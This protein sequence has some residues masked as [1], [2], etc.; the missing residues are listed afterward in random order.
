VVGTNVKK[1]RKPDVL[2]VVVQ[3]AIR[4]VKE[5]RLSLRVVA[6]RYGLTHTVLYY[7]I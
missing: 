7:R 6:S 3:K 4:A 2:E 1:R 5:R